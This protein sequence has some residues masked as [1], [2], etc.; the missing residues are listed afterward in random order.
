MKFLSIILLFTL[1]FATQAMDIKIKKHKGEVWVGNKIV[2]KP[3]VLK[4]GQILEVKGKQSFAHI[5]FDDGSQILMKE[6]KLLI[7][8]SSYKKDND[9]C[10]LDLIKGTL[11]SYI[12]PKK[13]R[14]YKFK[15][16][17]V[18]M[19]IRGTKFMLKSERKK[20]YICVCKG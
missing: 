11:F 1:S 13:K 15:T 20:D 12:N 9:D 8:K 16:K 10:I 7:K 5:V 4:E 2:L 17:L 18:S 6:G 14:S 19:G 3:M